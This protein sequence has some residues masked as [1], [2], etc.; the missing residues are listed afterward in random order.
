MNSFIL[1]SRY[2]VGFLMGDLNAYLGNLRDSATLYNKYVR[3][4]DIY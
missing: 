1:R 3:C 4:I 2:Y